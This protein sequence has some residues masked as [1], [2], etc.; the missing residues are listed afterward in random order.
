MNCKRCLLDDS[1]PGV[2]IGASGECNYCMLHDKLDAKHRNFNDLATQLDAIRAYDKSDYN[3]LIGI[4]GGVDSSYMVYNAVKIWKL[5]PLVIHFDNGWN[6]EIAANN[7]RKLREELKFTMITYH[8]N[9]DDLNKA[10]LH[11]SVTEADIPNDIAM[12]TLFMRT[13]EQFNIKYVF[14]GHDFRTE[15]SC[16]LGWTYMDGKY[17][18]SIGK[19]LKDY[20]NLGLWDQVKWGFK[21]FIHVRPLYYITL[22]KEEKK[23]ELKDVIGWEDYGGVHGENVYTDFV[24]SYLLPRKFGIDKRILYLSA[25]VRSGYISKDEAIEE[26]KNKPAFDESVIETIKKRLGIG[27][28]EFEAIMSMPRKTFKDFDSYHK[29]FMRYKWLVGMGVKFGVFPETFYNKY[30]KD[31]KF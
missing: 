30:T 17:L 23:K 6:T 2:T 22:T 29:T 26:F 27:D 10:F 15:G 8:Y 21:R 28:K 25:K 31:V 9:L 18:K 1:I 12:L 5:N 19:D 16:P 14:N 3:C 7:I 4:S 24:G 20:P 13:A 11:A